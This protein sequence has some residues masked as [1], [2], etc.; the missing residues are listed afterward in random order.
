M[1]GFQRRRPQC[2]LNGYLCVVFLHRGVVLRKI[3]E[4][5][6]VGVM[7]SHDILCV[8]QMSNAEPSWGWI[9]WGTTEFMCFFTLR[10]P[11]WVCLGMS[12]SSEHIKHAALLAAAIMAMTA[13]SSSCEI[14]Y[15][16]LL[17]LE[18]D[19]QFSC[20]FLPIW[21]DNVRNENWQYI[22]SASPDRNWG[23]THLCGTVPARSR[24]R[25]AAIRLTWLSGSGFQRKIYCTRKLSQQS[26]LWPKF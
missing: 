24:K 20:P 2:L 8:T 17:F 14:V 23:F 7:H 13:D 6:H 15:F 4:I 16:D 25:S 22:L 3:I 18:A 21:D 12:T 5:P 10:P 26:F 9:C 19:C 1:A 11:R